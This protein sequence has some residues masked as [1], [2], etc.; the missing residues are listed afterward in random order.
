VPTGDTQEIIEA[1]LRAHVRAHLAD[2]KAPRRIVL[3]T[4]LPRAP[5]GKPDYGLARD[6]V[7]AAL[8]GIAL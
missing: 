8:A 1:E 6:L 4:A 2:Y 3:V 7:T 5:N